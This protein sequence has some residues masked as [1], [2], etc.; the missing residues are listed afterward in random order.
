MLE[1]VKNI[2]FGGA[3]L[4]TRLAKILGELQ[5]QSTTVLS[6]AAAGAK[7]TVPGMS[8]QD[9]LRS[10]IAFNAGVPTDQTMNATVVSN[11]ATGTLT[12]AGVVA[13]DTATVNGKVFTC[14][15][16]P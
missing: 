13:G 4:N 10:V 11:R 15:L 1:S 9:T 12:L 5:G 2:G 7:V 14:I 6:G 3:D 16:L 8:Y